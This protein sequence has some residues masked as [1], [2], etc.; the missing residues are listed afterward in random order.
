ML[1]LAP[2][3]ISGVVSGMILHLL[4]FTQTNG[5]KNNPAKGPEILI[6]CCLPGFVLATFLGTINNYTQR[7]DK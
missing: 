5:R 1:K 6:T 2:T 7:P 3:V 4:L